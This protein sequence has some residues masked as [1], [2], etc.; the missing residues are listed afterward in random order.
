MT[1]PEEHIHKHIRV[2][3]TIFAA[4]MALTVVTVTASYL[5]LS[6]GQS[7]ALALFIATVK[8]SLV[9]CF[10]MHLISEKKVI[11]GVLII[12]AIFIFGFFFGSMLFHSDI[13]RN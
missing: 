3:I 5:H 11:Y 4:L 1:T 8:G 6:L 2:Y 9:A 13:V 10:F 12:A 7:I